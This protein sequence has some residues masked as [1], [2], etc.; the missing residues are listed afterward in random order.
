[1]VIG[2]RRQFGVS[3]ADKQKL[4]Q[5]MRIDLIPDIPIDH[6]AGGKKK[7]VIISTPTRKH[8][9]VKIVKTDD[10]GTESGYKTLLQNVYDAVLMAD[11]YGKIVNV[12]VRAREFFQYG[13]ED[14]CQLMIS[15]VVSGADETLMENIWNNLENERFTIVEAY[16]MRQDGSYFPAEIAFNKLKL[17]NDWRLCLFIRDISIRRQQQDM[18]RTVY[19]AIQ[20]AG[21]GIAIGNLAADLEYVNP[22]VLRMWGYENDD[23]LKGQNITGLLNDEK[24]IKEMLEKVA[25]EGGAWMSEVTV[26][27][28]NGVALDVQVSAACNVNSD[29][30]AVGIIFSFVDIGD[31]KRAEHAELEAERRRV[32]L[33]SLGAACHHLGQPATVLLAN[34]GVLQKKLTDTHDMVVKDLLSSSIEAMEG[35][36]EILHKLNTVNEYKTTQYLER[37]EGDESGESRILDI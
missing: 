7:S 31:R 13:T 17:D 10:S 30:D 1:M 27:R 4:V 20:N 8:R 22:A 15:D 19:S 29:G 11:T 5:T 24:M 28:L 16:C 3:M 2:E 35:L 34:L 23:H 12:N 37:L 25:E 26:K 14:L 6:A 21:N 9:P 18:L 33:E 32:M 36:G